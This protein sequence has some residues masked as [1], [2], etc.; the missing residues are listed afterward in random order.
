MVVSL[1][2][3]GG[4][5]NRPNRFC[6]TLVFIRR[7]R[8]DVLGRFHESKENYPGDD[9]T[10]AEDGEEVVE[11]DQF[12]RLAVERASSETRTPTQRMRMLG[13][14]RPT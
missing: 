7:H 8:F 10:E 4:N 5:G 13:T 9:E 6:G 3:M 11:H 14:Q 1:A 2:V 12:L